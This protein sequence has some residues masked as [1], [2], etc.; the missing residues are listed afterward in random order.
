MNNY[1]FTLITNVLLFGIIHSASGLD[2][3]LTYEKYPDKPQSYRPQGSSNMY[4]VEES[5][6]GYGEFPEIKSEQPLFS[7]I[8]LGDT[9]RLVMLDVRNKDDY[10]YNRLYFDANGN[11]DVTDD[12]VIDGKLHIYRRKSCTT[13]FPVIDT[14][15]RVDGK[16][17]P[18]SFRLRL[19]GRIPVRFTIIQNCTY[20]GSFTDGDSSY[21]MILGDTNCNG[22]FN[23]RSDHFSITSGMK[24]DYYDSQKLGNKLLIN[25]TLYEVAIDTSERNMNLAEISEGLV[26]L[27]LAMKT[28]RLSLVS[29][30]GSQCIMAYQPGDKIMIPEG[31]YR[32]LAYQD[33]REDEHGDLWSIRASATSESKAVSVAAKS[34]N[35][36]ELGEPFV[37]M[38]DI[39][40][41]QN[42]I[43][44]Q[45]TTW[46]NMRF[47]VEGTGRERIT[48]ICHIT[49]NK[50]PVKLSS[51]RKELPKEPVFRIVKTDGEI[52][53]QGS[54][55]YG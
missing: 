7:F 27:S 13:E 38:V 1:I 9:K 16:I 34:E 30:D 32:L 28:E 10:F 8:S 49:G 48:D 18:Y 19:T 6:S 41:I 39:F 24:F 12:P 35:R 52:V 36:L 33:F 42:Q 50:T 22:L 29:G 51:S 54:F 17:L 21:R 26:P 45:R 20:S 37:P 46:L 14:T 53:K 23:E 15:I 5:P 3:P 47:I 4:I 44:R 40:E 2:V 55:E 11:G 31:N 25:N 43:K